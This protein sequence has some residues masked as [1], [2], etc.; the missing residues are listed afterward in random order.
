MTS[1]FILNLVSSGLNVVKSLILFKILTFFSPLDLMSQY[2]AVKAF[3]SIIYYL[4]SLKIS[5]IF[6]V[7]RGQLNYNESQLNSLQFSISFVFFIILFSVLVFGF[8]F[9]SEVYIYIL[10][11]FIFYLNE[12]IEINFTSL[13]YFDK[14]YKMII[15]RIILLLQPLL[16]YF[17]F[18]YELISFD[19]KE[20]LFVEIF[21]LVFF[22]IVWIIY[23]I[24]EIN[25]VNKYLKIFTKNK[26]FLYNTWLNSISKISFD[27][28]PNYLLS[29]MVSDFIYVSYNVARTI[30]GSIDVGLNSIIQVL[31][32]YSFVHKKNKEKYY[33]LFVSILGSCLILSLIITYTYGP[34]IIEILSKQT[35]A[36]DITI[37]CL[38]ILIGS[39]F[40]YIFLHPIKQFFI[41]DGFIKY[42]SYGA[43]LSIIIITIFNFFFIKLYDIYYTSIVIS[44]GYS[45]III[46]ALLTKRLINEDKS[47]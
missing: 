5:D 13:R 17:S 20:I 6:Y 23:N 21:V 22:L 15:L 1:Q 11:F 4:L 36:N 35:Y 18:S 24:K 43:F 47:S 44:L 27:S 29:T 39:K 14:Y 12:I 10:A 33:K 9:L 40:I 25:S 38:L 42:L 8:I 7:Y 41:L 45:L 34:Y 32:N 2:F 3:S 26:D 37:T 28:L 30:F 46:L 19:L 16:I 31:N